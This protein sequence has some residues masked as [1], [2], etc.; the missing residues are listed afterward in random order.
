MST[1]SVE[2]TIAYIGGGSRGWAHILMSDLASCPDLTG[3][4]RLYD[5]DV[6][7]A[8]LNATLG[9]WLQTQPGV[10]SA[11][12]YEAV[13]SL[14][15][16]LCGADFVF[17][18]IQ[19][20]DLGL[21]A[22]EIAVAA[23]YGLFF[24]VGDTTGVPGLMRGVRA[25]LIYAE[26]AQAI[27]ETCPHAWVVNYSNPMTICTR[28]LAKV[29]PGLK[30]F[31]CCHEVFGT[32]QIL[33]ELAKAWLD[34][35]TQP[36]RAEIRVNVLGINHFTWL[37]RATYAGHDLL[38]LLRAHIAQPGVLRPF[39]QAEVEAHNDWFFDGRQVKFELFRRYGL[40]PAAGDRHLCEFVPGF[41]RSPAEL[42]RWGIIRTPVSYRVERWQ[43]GTRLAQDLMAG[44][45]PCSCSLPVR[46]W[47]SNCGRSSAWA[48]SSPTSTSPTFA[49][50]QTCPWA[51][52]WRP[53]RV[54]AATQCSRWRPGACP[55]G[56]TLW[57]R[58][59]WRTRR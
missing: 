46:R 3:I 36:T 41:T 29:A 24:P 18:S 26:F 30:V 43:L 17:I 23:Q 44:A 14:A 19:P 9:N 55:R 45:R 22:H 10:P 2:L 48:T 12:R 8:Q 49:R 35:P 40:L 15:E 50:W 56:S 47:C 39:T 1:Q 33:A 6:G 20:G 42:F 5:I 53:T 4:V 13:A 58:A 59:M 21:M 25:A 7:A 51:P 27:A 28:T 52:S 37:D 32:Q 38:A 31:G 54:S 16:A 11:W 34:L 57:W